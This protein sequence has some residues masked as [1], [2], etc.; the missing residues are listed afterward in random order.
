VHDNGARRKE[1]LMTNSKASQPKAKPAAAAKDQGK[2]DNVSHN[3]RKVYQATVAED[4][5]KE[6]LDL[7]KKLG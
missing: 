3:L 5:P 4:I 6:M 2:H 7:L 1:H